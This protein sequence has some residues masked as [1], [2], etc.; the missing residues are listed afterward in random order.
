[1]VGS[2][3]P[4]MGVSVAV[5]LATMAAAGA[6]AMGQGSLAGI[7]R[8]GQLLNRNLTAEGGLDWAV[9]GTGNSTSLA[10]NV[11]KNGGSGISDLTDITNGNP[12]RGLGQFGNFGGSF[13]DWSDGT[14]TASGTGVSVGLQHNGT[15]TA[16]SN[17]GEG[18]SFTVPADTNFRQVTV[19]AVVNNARAQL[20]GTL[21]DG[22]AAQSV[23]VVDS[24]GG[25]T[26]Y[27]F[28]L[29]YRAATAGQT[30]TV[31]LTCTQDATGDNSGNAAIQAV[32]FRNAAFPF[33][34]A[35]NGV[36]ASWD[37]YN[38]YTFTAGGVDYAY[39]ALDEA[40]TLTPSQ[41]DA[42]DGAGSISIDGIPFGV[43]GGPTF[44]S[45]GAPAFTLGP[46]KFSNLDVA[47]R[48]DTLA[49]G[50][51]AR[52]YYTFTNNTGAPITAKIRYFNDYGSDAATA[53]KST[54]SGVNARSVN[55]LW[56]VTDDGSDTSDDP[57][58]L[59]VYRGIGGQ[60]PDEVASKYF[61][62]SIDDDYLNVDFT[63]T[64]QPGQTVA[65]LFF[66]G[67]FPTTAEAQAASAAF[68]TTLGSDFTAGLTA[69]ELARVVNFSFAQPP[70]IT[71]PN[72]VTFTVGTA[73]TFTIT[74]TGIP[75][76]T[77]GLTGTLPSG[78]TFS[79]GVISGTPAAGTAGTYPLTATATAGE[80]GDMQML[81]LTVLDNVPEAPPTTPL[82]RLYQPSEEIHLFTT[83]A[84]EYAVLPSVGWRQEGV[85]ARVYTQAGTV[86]GVATVPL[87][88]LFLKV[89]GSHL[90]TA[91]AAEISFLLSLGPTLVVE[92]GVVGHVL[93]ASSGGSVAGT[94]ALRRLYLPGEQSHLF[95]T[96]PAEAA[97]LPSVG[98]LLEGVAAYVP[99][100]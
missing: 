20:T 5:C 69:D 12:L 95:T 45:G 46:A 81:T 87:R 21:S 63:V 51:Y 94:V 77:I 55:N 98:W 83:D 92:D 72:A 31:T 80:F 13:F 41:T 84:N 47:L 27:A 35:P 6:T 91:D 14:P 62:D 32:S 75:T 3:G 18:F 93:P 58:N 59:T 2:R 88:R 71:S 15:G 49:T 39:F 50:P 7:L 52:F 42:L 16:N 40:R 97:F 1:M 78:L 9:W 34:L 37:F 17:V 100:N 4:T 89:F 85:A 19:Y 74:A 90:L 44:L 48:V 54:S 22:S 23:Q 73:G 25:T 65:L 57:A 99:T 33:T 28:T 66:Q 82:Y 53:I 86:G 76:P 8:Q 70:A 64:V 26:S 67:I 68:S 38:D 60:V 24:T 36:N 11:R 56:M 79:N 96:D 29:T 43:T 61:D 30:L 10:P